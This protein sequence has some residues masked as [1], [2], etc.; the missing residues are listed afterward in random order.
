MEVDEGSDGTMYSC[1]EGGSD[2]G[3]EGTVNEWDEWELGDEEEVVDV[4]VGVVADG[5]VEEVDEVD[6]EANRVMDAIVF[7]AWIQV[8]PWVV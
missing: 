6:A 4:Q 3:S 5:E 1:D 8:V 2:C 7:K